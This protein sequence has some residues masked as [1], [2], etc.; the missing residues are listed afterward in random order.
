MLVAAAGSMGVAAGAGSCLAAVVASFLAFEVRSAARA[1]S[2]PSV[3]DARG[4]VALVC[5]SSGCVD[6]PGARLAW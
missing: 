1:W 6:G 3:G 5:P 4:G 2:D